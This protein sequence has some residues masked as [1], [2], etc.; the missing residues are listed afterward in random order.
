MKKIKW[1]LIAVISVMLILSFSACGQKFDPVAYV[2]GNFDLLFH[3]EASEEFVDSLEDVETVDELKAEYN[4]IIDFFTDETINSLNMKAAND[5]VKNDLHQMYI[6][7][8]DASK[9]EVTGNYSENNDEYEV[10]VIAYPLKT[11]NEV[12]NDENGTLTAKAEEAITADASYDDIMVTYI[13]IL[14][15]EVE[16]ALA[17]PTYG[18]PQ[19]FN[20]RVFI[21]DD[22]YYTVDEDEIAEI[23]SFLLGE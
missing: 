18:D 17:D 2:Q 4:E 7:L 12:I 9:Y 13:G 5:N 15:Q 8:L 11:Y 16:S 14:A 6:A 1:C 21:G 3:G 19:T 10:E 20:I 22:G 23:T